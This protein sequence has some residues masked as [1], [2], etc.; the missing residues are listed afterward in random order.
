MAV[1]HDLNIWVPNVS[2]NCLVKK[3]DHRLTLRSNLLRTIF[4]D[5][6]PSSSNFR[7]S[8]SHNSKLGWSRVFE[9]QA[10]PTK[11]NVILFSQIKYFL[12]FKD[13]MVKEDSPC[14]SNIL[15]VT[16]LVY[17]ALMSPA[18]TFLGSLT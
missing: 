15:S 17:M 9:Y 13:Q 1:S 8:Y 2:P 5:F 4:K 10:K 3:I 12:S 14:L 7:N 6:E 18:V 16:K 11:L